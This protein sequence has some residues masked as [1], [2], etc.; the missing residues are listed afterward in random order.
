MTEREVKMLCELVEKI[1]DKY[2]MSKYERPRLVEELRA[3][4]TDVFTDPNA[5][6]Q[7][8]QQ[9]AIG[10][11]VK[12]IDCDSDSYDGLIG[13]EVTVIDKYEVIRAITSEGASI[14]MKPKY[15]SKI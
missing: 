15:F 3:A 10:D 7:E 13:K 9:I 12:V 14:V 8:E 2:K 5:L 4:L 6:A 1:V 11:K